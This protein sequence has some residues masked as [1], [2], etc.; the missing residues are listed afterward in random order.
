LYSLLSKF[1]PIN[2]AEICFSGN[3]RGLLP[4][5]DQTNGIRLIAATDILS[6]DKAP[7]DRR[8]LGLAE[9]IAQQFDRQMQAT[10]SGGLAIWHAGNGR[11]DGGRDAAGT[12][13]RTAVHETQTFIEKDETQD[14]TR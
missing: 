6:R 9:Q 2:S 4:P 7:A 10:F 11:S 13:S 3:C 14:I 1:Q 12:T 5:T 8:A